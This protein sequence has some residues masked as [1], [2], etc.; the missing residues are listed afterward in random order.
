MHGARVA[1]SRVRFKTPMRSRISSGNASRRRT[2]WF[3]RLASSPPPLRQSAAR[4]LTPPPLLQRP[5]V[6]NGS[7]GS[8]A[9]ITSSRRVQYCPGLRSETSRPKLPWAVGGSRFGDRGRR[10]GREC[11]A[12]SP[13]TPGLFGARETALQR[14][15]KFLRLRSLYSWPLRSRRE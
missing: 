11:R 10:E 3:P 8:L 1:P 13:P 4:V 6:R 14:S 7:S 2:S 15:S 12:Q 9:E 5:R